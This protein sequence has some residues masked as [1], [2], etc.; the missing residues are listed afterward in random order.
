LRWQADRT[1]LVSPAHAM[2][3]GGAGR[4]WI[5]APRRKRTRAGRAPDACPTADPPARPPAVSVYN[6]RLISPAP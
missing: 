6:A 4:G 5:S 1:N 3:D 2:C